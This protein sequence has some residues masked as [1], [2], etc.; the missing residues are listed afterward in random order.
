M[1]THYALLGL[2]ENADEAD[3]RRAYRALALQWHPDKHPQQEKELAEQEFKAINE[4]YQILSQPEQRCK[5][6]KQCFAEAFCFRARPNSARSH[7]TPSNQRYRNSEAQSDSAEWTK[8]A[9]RESKDVNV[10]ATK[11]GSR[12][13]SARTYSN[14]ARHRTREPR[15]S[16]EWTKAMF[17]GAARAEETDSPSRHQ[18]WFARGS[19]C[20]GRAYKGMECVE[21]AEARQKALTNL[22][23]WAC[24]QSDVFLEVRGCVSVGEVNHKQM[25]QLAKARRQNTVS[26]LT[27]TCG[28]PRERCRIAQEIG[29]CHQGVEMSAYRKLEIQISFHPGS[30]ELLQD[31]S[32]VLRA[33]RNIQKRRLIVEIAQEGNI[34]LARQRRDA[35]KLF[36][37]RNGFPLYLLSVRIV[38]ETVRD[39][40]SISFYLD[41]DIPLNMGG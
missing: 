41:T 13:N 8:P 27:N 31:E 22:S 9:R 15:M 2:P 26:F 29:D 25:D 23:Q 14:A 5:Y 16:A 20:V 17:R 37:S 1:P 40:Q 36:V 24:Q 19:A 32:I 3:I 33:L 21:L 28:L 7:S 11:G 4:A 38:P 39:G 34:T 10:G 12:P 30:P 18:I 6:D 35:L